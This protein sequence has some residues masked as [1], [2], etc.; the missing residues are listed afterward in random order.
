MRREDWNAALAVRDY[1]NHPEAND[2]PNCPLLLSLDTLLEGIVRLKIYPGTAISPC[3]SCGG[4]HRWAML[5]QLLIFGFDM[6]PR[7]ESRV[8]DAFYESMAEER[9][10]YGGEDGY[11]RMRQQ[12]EAF[13]AANPSGDVYLM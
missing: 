10:F 4:E 1:W 6:K 12:A 11:R 5:K 8:L 13:F 9:A 2:R 7:G 3:P